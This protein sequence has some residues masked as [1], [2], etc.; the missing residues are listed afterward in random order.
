MDQEWPKTNLDSAKLHGFARFARFQICL[1][2]S[3]MVMV[4]EK[5]HAEKK[6]KGKICKNIQKKE[7]CFQKSL[8]QRFCFGFGFVKLPW[9]GHPCHGL[10][11]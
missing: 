6:I 5:K 11:F 9:L 8:K 4:L 10:P 3:C 7:K 2:L 1:P